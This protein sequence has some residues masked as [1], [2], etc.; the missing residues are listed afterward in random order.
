MRLDED[1]IPVAAAYLMFGQRTGRW[2]YSP[3]ASQPADRCK[4]ALWTHTEPGARRRA[5]GRT[6]RA[7]SI[8]PA[9]QA[10]ASQL[11][12]KSSEPATSP[13][14]H[15]AIYQRAI[16]RSISSIHYHQYN[17]SSIHPSI[18]LSIHPSIH[19]SIHHFIHLPIHLFFHFCI[20]F[21]SF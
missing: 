2:H 12:S 4:P 16:Y 1:R 3:R 8:Q 10:P 11:A 7:R 6:E 20:S 19:P 21:L 9:S 13:A 18:H 14:S 15:L 17:Q 5:G